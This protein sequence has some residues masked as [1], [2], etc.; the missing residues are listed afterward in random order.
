MS[1]V[2]KKC[3]QAKEVCP[4]LGLLS[5]EKKNA[6]LQSIADSL[7]K[8][9]DLILKANEKDIKAS[10]KAGSS[11]SL[12]DRLLLNDK[13]IEDMAAG[14]EAIIF[15]A[16]PIGKVSQD[17]TLYNGLKL[18]QV[19]VP[20][21]VIAMIYEAR[22]NVTIDAAALALKAGNAIVLRGSSHALE[23]NR[24]LVQCLQ[25]ALLDCDLP[26]EAAVLIEAPGHQATDE[27]L[28][29]DKYVDV[30]IP[31]GGAALITHVKQNATVPILETGIGNCHIF[32][33]ESALLQMVLPIVINAKTQ[34]PSVC[35]AAEKLLIH[36]DWPIQDGREVLKALKEKGVILH[37]D[38]ESQSR[39]PDLIDAD[40]SISEY[41]VEYLD[42]IMGV[43]I[44][45]DVSDAI[46][47]INTYGSHHSEAILTQ[48]KTNKDRF[49]AMVDSAALY[50]NTS[51]RFTDGFEYGYGAE[52][53]IS[54]QK[55]HAR[56]PMALEQLCSSKYLIEGKGQ[57]RQ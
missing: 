52:I 50:Y 15:L 18:K 9:R 14:V 2:L 51:T 56:G 49:F 5:T 7:R 12:L 8:N 40:L 4:L 34:R 39:W 41:E 53:G 57:I 19:T 30:L 27:L 43:M 28:H 46:K 37:G 29:L 36:T 55:L 44:V 31:R 10:K 48:N 3:Q 16:D 23:S 24:A 42:L 17:K 54:T 35:N 1:E 6:L 45:K 20:L 22:P 21:G 32:V 13:R 26:K 11:N 47:H 38:K 33:D 25:E